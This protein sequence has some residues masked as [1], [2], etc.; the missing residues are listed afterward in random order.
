M[1]FITRHGVGMVQT[2]TTKKNQI[3]LQRKRIA[4]MYA[5]SEERKLF[6][7][8]VIIRQCVLLAEVEETLGDG[9]STP[10]KA[11]RQYFGLD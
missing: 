4:E 6:L 5:I 10:S 3:L 9:L 1:N 8:E 11:I 2:W 7:S